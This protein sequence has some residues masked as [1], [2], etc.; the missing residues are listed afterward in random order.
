[1]CYKKIICMILS[2]CVIVGSGSGFVFADTDEFA[3]PE[4]LTDEVITDEETCES[5]DEEE[6]IEVEETEE[7][8]EVVTE[9]EDSELPET[10]DETDVYVEE[11]GET[12]V[13]EETDISPYDIE[14]NE[15]NFP[16]E[17]FRNYVLAN[18]AGGDEWLTPEEREA[19]VELD[20]SGKQI[21]SLVGIQ[22]FEQLAILDISDNLIQK[23]DLSENTQLRELYCSDNYLS[24]LELSTIACLS[25]AVEDGERDTDT[26]DIL[27]FDLQV[28]EAHY[29]LSCDET[30]LIETANT[31]IWRCIK[32]RRL[33]SL[34]LQVIMN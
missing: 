16:D 9:E 3:V 25:S 22:Y 12:Y 18:I 10:E 17:V 28:E 6:I 23:V 7:S 24:T 33:L 5:S 30:V 26:D 11:E 29:I 4:E 15:N 1:M 27:I 21:T 13:F 34:S 31:P 8:F 32:I 20:L 2:V 19:V 14:V